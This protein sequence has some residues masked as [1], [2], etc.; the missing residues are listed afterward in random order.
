MEEIF[1]PPCAP[2]LMESTRALGYSLES[3]IADLLD[4]SISADS[5]NIDI[6]Y[7]PWDNPYL[8]ILDNGRGMLPDELTSAM[9]YGSQNPLDIRDKNDLGRFGLGLKTASLSQCRC[10]TV[11]SKKDGIL[12]GRRWDLDVISQRNDW[13]LL[14]LDQAQMNE[15]PGIDG[16]TTLKHGTLVIWHKLDRLASGVGSL[17]CISPLKWTMCVII[18]HWCFIGT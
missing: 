13:I 17:R 8:Y 12:S 7:R 18:F 10:L 1:L 16:L 11:I 2:V 6:E 4:N 3:A 5:I 14:K 9:R 15:M